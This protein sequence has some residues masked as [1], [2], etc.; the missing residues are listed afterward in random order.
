[1]L[2]NLMMRKILPRKPVQHNKHRRQNNQ[3]R[4]R[5]YDVEG[6]FGAQRAPPQHRL[7]WIGGDSI[8]NSGADFVGDPIHVEAAGRQR[9]RLMTGAAQ[10]IVVFEEI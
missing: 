3:R 10:A 9:R 8:F 5:E 1:M 7:A 6:A 4:Q 2:R